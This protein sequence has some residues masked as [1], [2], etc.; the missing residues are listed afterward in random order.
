M[1]FDIVVSEKAGPARRLELESQDITVGRAEENDVCL[2][3]RNISKQHTRIAVEDGAVVVRD[4]GSTN[5][6]WVNGRRIDGPQPVGPSDRICIG[7]FALAV[8]V[9]GPAA[10]APTAAP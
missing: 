1:G 9:R 7:D 10:E 4:L 6:T 8:E 5:G 3:R 2:P